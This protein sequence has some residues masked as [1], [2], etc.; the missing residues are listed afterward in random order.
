M[1][2]QGQEKQKF[3]RQKAKEHVPETNEKIAWSV[4]AVKNCDWKV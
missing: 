2:P 3:I 4:H 1:I